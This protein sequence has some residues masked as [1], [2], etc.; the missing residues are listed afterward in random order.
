MTD[1]AEPDEKKQFTTKFEGEHVMT[2]TTGTRSR[3]RKPTKGLKIERIFTTPGVHPYDEV[4][5]ELRDV[6]QQNWKTGETIFDQRGVEY[7]EFWSANASTIVT[8]KY[9]R[10]AL[11]TDK[12][13]KSLK[14]LIDRVVLTY[15]KAGKDNGYFGT[16]EDAE[17]FEHELTYALLHQVFSFNSPVW[18]NVGT[19]SPQQVSACQPYDAMV[20]TPAGQIPI[21]KLVESDAVGTKVYD[22]HGLTRI[23]AVKANGAKDVLRLHTK[24]GHALDVTADHLVWKSSG[25]G[26]GRFV[27][28]GTLRPRDQ[29]EWHRRTS[30]GE[31]EITQDDVAEAA[32]AGWMQSDG[33]VGQYTGT[34]RSLT[35]EAQ[36]VTPSEFAWVND[37]LDVV[38]PDVH[39]KVRAFE[40]QSTEL[41]GQR[42]R[43]YGNHLTE[44]VQEW[45]LRDRGTEMEVPARLFEAP[46]P[47]VA[48]YLRSIFQAE[49][50]VSAR[51]RSTVVEVDMIGE[52]LIRGMQTLLHRFGIFARV[53]FKPD[54]RE[55]RHGCSTL[56]IQNAGDR[57]IFADEIGFIDP[58]K[59]GKL[60][61]SFDMPGRGAGEVKCLEIAR[62]EDLGE[63]EVYDIQTES[64]EYLSDSLR[65]HNCFI[66]SVDD[67]MDSILNWYKEE[68]FIFKGGSGAGLNLSRIRSSKELL[69]SGG[70][71]SGPV[72]FMRGADASAGTIKSG[73]ATRRAAKMVVLDVDHP[74][75]EEFVET[76]AREEDKIRA[77]RDAGFD[78]DLGGKDI[79]SVQYQNA[80]N[81]VRVTDE[82]MRAVEDGTEFGLKARGTGEVIETVDAR[83]LFTKIAKAA[84]E[85]A[86]PGLQYD[87]TINDWHTNPETGRIAASNPCFT[88]DTLVAVVDGRGAVPIGE[89]VGQVVDVYSMDSMGRSVI[90]SMSKIRMTRAGAEIVEVALDDE[91]S[92]R[93]TPDHPFMLRDG[94]YVEAKDLRAGDSLKRF[95][96]KPVSAAATVREEALALNHKVVSVTPAGRADVYDGEVDETHNFAI[97]TSGEGGLSVGALSGVFVHNCSEYMSLDNSSCNLASLNLLKFLR[98]DDTFDVE[99]YQKVT[100]L[101]ITAMD[102]SIC[103]ADFPTEAIGDTTRNYRQLGIGYA[104]LGA[105]L[106]AT[107]HGYDSDG[108]R[109]LAA[110]LTSLLTGAAYKRSAELAGAVGPYNGYAR[111][112]EPHKRV[113]RKH[114]AANDEVRTLNSM[115][116]AVHQAATKAWD[117]VVKLGEKN[118]Y[119][120]AQASVLAPTGTISFMMDADTTGIEPDFSLVKFK[121]LVGGGS[122]QIVNQTI[123]RALKLLG[124]TGET[125]EAIVEYIAEKGHVID[126]PGLKPEHY[127]VFD[128][129]MGARAISPMG[130]V[131]MMGAVQPFL[132]GAISK[133]VNLPETATIEEIEDV[134]LQG[135]KL[136]LKALAVY[137]DNCKVGQPLSSGKNEKAEEPVPEKVVEYRPVRKRLPKRRPSQTTSFSVGGAEGYLTAGSY[138]DDG[139]G[140]L[141]LKF[142]KQGSTLAGVMDAFSIAVSIGMQYGVPLETFVEKFTNLRFEPAGLTDDPDVRMAQSIMDYVFRRLAL[143]YLDFE[144]RSFIGIHTAEERA[145]Q[146][147]TGSYAPATDSD[148]DEDYEDQIESYSQ[149]VGETR[150]REVVVEQAPEATQSGSGAASAREVEP[151]IHSSADLLEKFQGKA[152]DAPMCMT[153]GTKM[154]PAGSC[155]VCEGCGSTSGCS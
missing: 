141:F 38:F 42:T 86:D 110:S 62:V 49:G 136:G 119:R 50:F 68:G 149:S 118:G 125:T 55:D 4:T 142:G 53:G 84:W 88:A 155:Y 99:T 11:G 111:N 92:V 95:D 76:K 148:S 15:V 151:E 21:G 144:T 82:F 152:A 67:S 87:D 126:A 120:N 6:I 146:L 39:R 129:A 25:V 47:V 78:M 139:L 36:T 64:G 45:G 96:S 127:E 9:F 123:P 101:V 24:A 153:C 154:R 90:R 140:E 57:R 48:A 66:L 30:S 61:R 75:I 43:V 40:T 147:E 14:Q 58:I 13:E 83:E 93:C 100:E 46:L 116:S 81:S 135:W 23:L 133:T 115:D 27:E 19:Q 137:R 7:P 143:D 131:Q 65:V 16:D 10:G 103:F 44:F 17:V 69:S 89:L 134:H 12:R 128:C 60:E 73:G 28:A 138:P 124:Y 80:N 18:F 79:V 3:T 91:T 32:L 130:H 33:F 105:L 77:L 107:G 20:S 59:S 63:M 35:M 26:S 145:R 122:M 22:A 52:K 54:P 8:T 104:N 94:S 121:K 72:S 98:D 34:N 41:D 2:E 37:A 71:A 31:A 117:E 51:A 132:S 56:R 108:G 70:T 5:W 29:L 114:Q 109:S 106:M 150:K 102:I 74:D 85:C 1:D 97:V 112:A 113:M